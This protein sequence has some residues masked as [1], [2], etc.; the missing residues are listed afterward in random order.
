MADIADIVIRVDSSQVTAASGNLNNLQKNTV[1][2]LSSLSRAGAASLQYKREVA[3]LN[4]ANR[5]SILTHNELARSLVQLQSR[6]NSMGLAVDSAGNLMESS[7]AKANNFGHKVQQV[8]YQVGDFFVQVQSGTNVM[9]AFGQQATQLAGLIPGV[10]GA[11]LGIGISLFTAIGATLMRS[12]ES[13]GTFQDALDKVKDSLSDT[14]DVLGLV[15]GDLEELKKN[16][17]DLSSATQS[18]VDTKVDIALRG[19]AD[20]AKSL[21]S[22]LT[23]MYNGNAWGNTS[24]AQELGEVFRFGTQNTRELAAAMEELKNQDTLQ[25]QVEAAARLREL[26]LAMA[27][28]VE[29]MTSDER[30]FYIAMVDAEDASRRLLE[31]TEKVQGATQG[32]AEAQKINVEHAERYYQILLEQDALNK[33]RDAAVQSL[34]DSRDDELRKLAQQKDML[35]TILTFGKDSVEVKEKEAQFARE[36]AEAELKRL[37]IVGN[38]LPPLMAAYDAMASTKAEVENASIAAEN[39][40]TAL[41]AAAS[42]MAQLS[43]FSA[44]IDVKI[45]QAAAKVEALKTGANAANASLVAGLRAEAEQR[46]QTAASVAVGADQLREINRVYQDSIKG[47]EVLEGLNNQASALEESTKKGAGGTNKLKKELDDA[48][49]AAEQLR[50]QLEAPL[51]SAVGSIS[52]AFGNFVARGLRDFK[53]FVKDIIGSFKNMIAQMIAMAVKNRIMLSLGIGGVTGTAAA[54]GQVAGIGN[55]GGMLGS[56]AGGGVAGSGLL[57][58][59][60]AAMPSFLGGAGNGLFAVGANAAA[61]G[62][63]IAATIG[64]V[65]APL[66]AVAAVFAFFKKKTKELDSGL[67]VTVS[68]MDA[69]VETFK[70]VQ[71]TQF[72]GLSKKTT[73][74]VGAADAEVANPIT[75]AVS[76]IQS[77]ILKMAGVLNIGSDAFKDF[78]YELNISLKGLTEEQAAAKVQEELTKVGDAFADLIPNI[79]SFKLGAETTSQTLVRLFNS[80]QVAN[81]YFGQLANTMFEVSLAGADLASNLIQAFGSMDAFDSS[82]SS[83]VQNF[84]SEAEQVAFASK[85]V[86]DAF[87]ALGLAAP[88]TATAFR[89]LV[90]SLMRDVTAGVAGASATLAGVL[91]TQQ[92]VVTVDTYNA[93]QEA[94]RQAAAQ[95]ARQAAEA[96]REEQIRRVKEEKKRREQEKQQEE[97]RIAQERYNLETQLLQLQGNTLELRRRELELLDPTNRGLQEMVWKLEDAQ[98]ALEKFGEADFATRVDYLRAVGLAKN[99]VAAST[100]DYVTGLPGVRPEIPSIPGNRPSIPGFYAGGMH[101]GGPRIV[102]ESGP[103]LEITGPS[104]IYSNQDTAAMFRDPNLA[105]AMEG[106]R[107]EVSGLRSEQLQLQVEISKNV[108]RTYDIERKWDTDGLPPVRV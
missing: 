63:G 11:G 31:A 44:G 61:A 94:A 86:T 59:F 104:R 96:R 26:F 42:A 91:A 64:A 56:F 58:G 27:G 92:D 78:S 25:G 65:A 108:K 83:F 68:N 9:V 1:G 55:A 98:E 66:L 54:A 73:T 10:L 29:K 7:Q 20:A 106:L 72:F 57:G 39:L 49:K 89:N 99:A 33:E 107:K 15:N 22:E 71:T 21:R 3:L 53:G 100:S 67:R 105:S 84:Y 90:E 35:Q 50:T 95:A 48:A 19:M 12:S 5:Q 47:I 103:E 70:T 40:E 4:E 79:S 75:S 93:Q 101:M 81:S 37:G 87:K 36:A 45:A 60:G 41:Q 62:G 52:D 80:L 24:R 97:E 8:G 2:L 13:A 46:R 77:D 69:L 32:T 82:M 88:A 102:G 74:T 14:D 43:G 6:Y 85:R 17:G 34:I 23:E 30:D 38:F 76:A 18:L 16:F 51:V 28:P